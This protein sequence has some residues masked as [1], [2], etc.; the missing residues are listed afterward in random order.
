MI[1]FLGCRGTTPVSG[2]K[3]L[4]YGGN[5]PSLFIPLN[6]EECVI[7]DC[8]TGINRI[9]TDDKL[10]YKKY[11]IF[12]THLHWDHIIGLPTFKALY[13]SEAEINIYIQNKSV[14]HPFVFIKYL[15]NPPY[16]PVSPKMLQAKINYHLVMPETYYT[17]PGLNVIATEGNHPNNS[18]IYKLSF[19]GFEVV[20]ATDFEHSGNNKN[21][22]SF[23][24]GCKYLVYD[25]TFMPDDFLGKTDGIPKK[26]WG[27]STYLR[28][29]ELS[30][31]AD[32]EYLVLYHH[33]PDYDDDKIDYMFALA[34]KIFPKTICS[35]DGMRLGE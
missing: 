33:N 2:E 35:F 23:S 14:E 21:L 18:L 17:F 9:N 5:T 1:E 24:K 8:G 29:A 6:K 11:H 28:G 12:F 30:R 27:H 32:V 31:K 15:F 10:I 25:T 34:K 16:F 3:Y 22:I 26:G 7:I 4:K 19:K 13:N 20:F